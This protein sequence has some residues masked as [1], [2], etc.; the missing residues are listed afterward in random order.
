MK[1]K[2]LLTLTD[3]NDEGMNNSQTV[4]CLYTCMQISDHYLQKTKESNLINWANLCISWWERNQ[5]RLLTVKLQIKT[6][7]RNENNQC[8]VSSN[9]VE[10]WMSINYAF[11]LFL[12]HVIWNYWKRQ[13]KWFFKTWLLGFYLKW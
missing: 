5:M 12:N 8:H 2:T 4:G 10:S 6:Q 11:Q 7:N 9:T 13:R 1:G 3:S